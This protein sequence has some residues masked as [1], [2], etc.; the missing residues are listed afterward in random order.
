MASI[1]IPFAARWEFTRSPLVGIWD[2]GFVGLDTNLKLLS[3][4][5][6]TRSSLVGTVALFNCLDGLRGY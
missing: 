2:Y 1:L 6:F 5:K 3:H 4:F